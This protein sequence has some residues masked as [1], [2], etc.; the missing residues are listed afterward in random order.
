MS[1]IIRLMGFDADA[2][3]ELSA[4]QLFTAAGRI[5]QSGILTSSHVTMTGAL[6]NLQSDDLTLTCRF[7]KADVLSP[8]FFIDFTFD[9][10][11]EVSAIRLGVVTPTHAPTR[12]TICVAGEVIW[13]INGINASA[14]GLT[15][16]IERSGGAGQ[17]QAPRLKTR[18]VSVF[19]AVADAESPVEIPVYGYGVDRLRDVEF[20][21]HGFVYGVVKD[22]ETQWLLQRRVRLFRSR[23]GYLV[24]E[25]WS[26][27]DGSYRFEGINERYEY[28]IEAWDHEKNYY[29]AVANNQIPEVVA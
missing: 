18:A 16:L 26:G 21:G 22:H 2:D 10:A 19:A 14:V 11:V 28:D 17:L 27:P 25:T 24:R 12:I 8:G 6:E 20:S 5:D 15:A 7:A 1:Y 29:S 13:D 4:L 9:A 23:D 3:M